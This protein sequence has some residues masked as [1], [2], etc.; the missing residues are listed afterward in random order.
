MI[1][2]VAFI[3]VLLLMWLQRQLYSKHWNDNLDVKISYKNVDLVVGEE[4]E[5]VEV[6]TNNKS[7]PLPVFHVKFDTPKTFIF[8]NEDNSSVTDYYYRDDVFTVLGHQSVTRKLKFKCTK[9]GCFYMNDITITS[10]DLFLQLI[11]TDKRKNNAVIHV[12]PKKIDTG[13]F[14]IPFKT[15]TGSYVTNKTLVEDPFEFRGIRNY[16]PFDN[17]KSINWKASAKNN[18]LMVNN[19]FMTS[20]QNIIILLNIDT[21]LYSKNEKLIEKIISI[22]SSLAERFVNAGIPVGLI[23]NGR[24]I[25]TNEQIH[26]HSGSGSNHMLVLDK[27]LARLDP[28]ADLFDFASIMTNELKNAKENTYYIIISNNR[29]PEIITPYEELQDISADCFFIVPELKNVEVTE[30]IS[31]MIK[32]DIEL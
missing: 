22:A 31:N 18:E 24:D 11:L 19:F 25:Y 2:L 27:D 4:N 13:L 7:L 26:R 16:Q 1:L 8:E 20:S 3:C 23:T 5:L 15:I 12:Y 21:Q 14:D 32:W 10:S 28:Y 6:I 17:M 9:R 30:N 29:K